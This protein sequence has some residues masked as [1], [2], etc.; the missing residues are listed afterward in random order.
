MLH[1]VT[2]ERRV[3]RLDVQFEMRQQ[4]IFAQK[5]QARGGVEIV[6]MLRRFF[7]FRLDVKLSL[8]ADLLFVGDGEVQ[9]FRKVIQLAFHVGVEQR[10]VAFAAAPER[11]AF[12]AEFVRHFHRLLDLRGG[13]SE[14]VGIAARAGTVNETR[15]RKQIRRA[16]E[17][18]DAGAFLFFFQNFR[19]GVEILVGFRKSFAFGRN[20]AVMPAIIWRTEFFDE[21]KRDVRAP[22]RIADGVRAVVPRTLHRSGTKRVATRATERVPVD[23]RET[24]MFAHRLARDDFV[25]IVVLESERVFRVRAFVIDFVDGR[26]CSFHVCM[27]VLCLLF[28][29]RFHRA[30]FAVRFFLDGKSFGDESG[31]INRSMPMATSPAVR[32]RGAATH[33]TSP[34]RAHI[35]PLWMARERCSTT[36]GG[37]S[38]RLPVMTTRRCPRTF[39]A[40]AIAA[41]AASSACASHGGMPFLEMDSRSS[42]QEFSWRELLAEK[43]SSR[44]RNETSVSMQPTAPQPHFRRLPGTG[45]WPI[46]PLMGSG[47]A[48]GLPWTIIAPPTPSPKSTSR[49]SSQSGCAT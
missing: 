49:K 19:D 33:S 6:L 8:E 31:T 17:Q 24:Q 23:H 4:I 22:L 25:G 7:R 30:G 28:S 26:E 1:R 38:V 16:P 36:A 18:F 37:N 39:S 21:F 46:S 13:K 40:P 14:Y 20:I 29:W 41:A 48:S 43:L 10:H 47:L 35:A 32:R 9:Q 3:V 11:V 15:I 5:V 2:G 12:T 42:A 27:F 34:K 45:V 44:P